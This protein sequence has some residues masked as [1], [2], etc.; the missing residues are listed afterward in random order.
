MLGRKMQSQSG[1][2]RRRDWGTFADGLLPSAP[3]HKQQKHI[4]ASSL[5][6]DGKGLTLTEGLVECVLEGAD[7]PR[8]PMAPVCSPTTSLPSSS[9]SSSTSSTRSMYC[10]T[11]FLV[12]YTP[13]YA[14]PSVTEISYSLATLIS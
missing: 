13:V 6:P 10:L 4:P 1:C 8:L 12:V 5:V 3:L 14:S 2:R 11:L 7:P 9:P